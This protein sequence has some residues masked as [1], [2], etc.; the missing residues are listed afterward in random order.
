MFQFALVSS[1][2]KPTGV[3]NKTISGIDLII[4]NSIY[5][6]DFETAIIRP[7]IPDHFPGSYAFKL[8]RSMSS[9]NHQKK[10]GIFIN[11]QLMKVQ[12]QQSNDYYAKFLGTQLKA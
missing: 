7:D 12:R 1:I 5:E 2:N 10:I 6:N 4:A 9:E 3:R 8:K 11:V